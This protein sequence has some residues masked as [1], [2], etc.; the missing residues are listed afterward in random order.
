MKLVILAGGLR[1]TIHEDFEG[2]PKPMV[3]IGERPILWHIM[4]YYSHFGI[5]DF[6][7]CGGYKVN[8]LKDYFRDYYI[9]QSDITVDLESNTIQ[10]HK[11][12]TEDWKVTVVDTGLNTTP[13]KRIEA[14]KEYLDGEDFIVTYGDCLSDLDVFDFCKQHREKDVLVT[15]MLSRP[16][17]RNAV[18]G[19]DDNAW[20]NGCTFLYSSRIWE[21]VEQHSEKESFYIPFGVEE[22]KV[23]MYKHSSF[24]RPVETVR[25]RVELEHMWD[26]DDAVWKIWE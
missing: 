22:T 19:E 5:N 14:V 6:I 3:E 9:Y 2:I 17:G 7:I 15:M 26:A 10:I 18:I 4:K 12:I 11:K 8:M 13:G 1:S 24:W 21:C 25:D 16:T 23:N 20:T